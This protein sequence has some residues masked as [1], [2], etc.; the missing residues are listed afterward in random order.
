[1]SRMQDQFEAR[2]RDAHKMVRRYDNSLKELKAHF[3]ERPKAAA[4][5]LLISLP[6]QLE[7]LRQYALS[8]FGV[9]LQD[10][11]QRQ[12]HTWTHLADA[13][14]Y[15]LLAIKYDAFDH[16][17]LSMIMLRDT[18]ER[19]ERLARLVCAAFLL[20]WGKIPGIM[21]VTIEAFQKAV[22][23]IANE[24]GLAEFLTAH[25]AIHTSLRRNPSLRAGIDELREEGESRFARLLKE[26]PAEAVVT[27]AERPR[28]WSDLMDLRTEVAR[29]LE[30]RDAA[31]EKELFT[32]TE[33]EREKLLK[34][35]RDAGLPPQEF[36]LYKLLIGKP[37]LKNKDYGAQLGISASHVGVLKSRINKT[38]YA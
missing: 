9:D 38:L 25:L 27:Y 12:K 32:F 28:S 33:R 14:E 26:L 4:Q 24:A 35:G 6:E 15:T 16:A 22:P 11:E 34:R 13:W 31:K 3:N 8:R 5:A 19:G 23:R 18:G 30:K 7:V 29:R 21:A 20:A 37:G 17:L 1:M 36:E 2:I 10:R